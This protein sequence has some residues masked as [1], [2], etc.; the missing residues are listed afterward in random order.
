MKISPQWI[1]EFV[2][3]QVDNRQLAGELT[4]HGI[5]VEGIEHEGE[6][7]VY[8]V[9]FTSNR[10]D[11]MN[12][13]GVARECAA[14][15]DVDLKPLN[16]RL[17]AMAMAASAGAEWDP[18][19]D[20]ER[21][22]NERQPFTIE[23]ED[24]MGCARYTGRIIRG[25]TIGASPEYVIRRL[26]SVEQRSIS[27]VADATNYVLWEMGH[28]THAFDLDLL[29]GGKII[30]RRAREGEKLTTLDG[31]E[32]RL[33]KED[34]VIADARK[35]V[36]LAGV[37]GGADTAISEKTRNVLIEAAWFDPAS[38][39]RTAKRHGM[40]T[41]ASHRFERGAD[42][43]ATTVACA[44]VAQLVLESAGGRLDGEIDTVA[45]GIDRP[46]IE[47]RRSEVQRILGKAIADDEITRVL[48]RLGFVV[49]PGRPTPA[50][51]RPAGRSTRAQQALARS[52]AGT[53]LNPALPGGAHA[54]VA[55]EPASYAVHIP[56]WR[57]DVERE[58]DVIEEIARIHGFENFENTLPE[59]A[60]AVLELPDEH[61]D[62]RLRRTLLALGYDEAMSWTF[63]GRE[64]A[65]AFTAG[66]VLE[67]ANPISDEA[68]VMRT[69]LLPGMLQMLAWNLNRG[70]NDVRL[71]E[72]G[73]VFE[74]I[75]DR[76]DERKRISLGATGNAET[77]DWKTGPRPYGFFDMKG[78]VE[79]LLNAFEHRALYFDQ[80]AAEF[81]H[82]GR[83]ARAVMD[84]ATVAR[85]GQLHPEL[86]AARKLRQ[87]VYIAE[88]YLERLYQRALR[89]PRYTPIPRYPAVD[90]DFS[91]LFDETVT[92]ERIKAAVEAL[93]ISELRGFKPVE[94][95]RGGSVPR[96]KYSVLL[97]A[98]FQS[99][100]RT[101]RDEEVSLW[102]AQ[103]I[104][105]LQS[106]G[107]TLRG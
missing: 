6:D 21:G 86:A 25:V 20:K 37:M 107:G 89:S 69:S 44:R 30:V 68:A 46:T 15:F 82:P 13:Y 98:G 95:F 12:H 93:R 4:L 24:A 26:Q 80:H 75:G 76:V 81:F 100:E 67:L 41:D 83:S 32:R 88:I 97:R 58:I 40:H 87:D 7:M 79:Q 10:P 56:S 103:I 35:A 91:F 43:G 53:G 73:H 90:R 2:D 74:R 39:R 66:Q 60:G 14:I 105:Q 62:A 42:Y 77:A 70:S 106:L 9:E 102:A 71:F 36:A 63:I 16:V 19:P 78:D 51:P 84:G 94:V 5:A 34:L 3:L 104:K 55:E 33:T 22:K 49:T 72:A 17:P 38:I 45:R 28:P 96:G 8:E 52:D 61:K 29:E 1:R 65:Q 31:V 54:A 59:F 27:N 11:A 85:F 50:T 92:F 48:R 18:R 23:I 99:A 101:L 64:D 47:L 57:L